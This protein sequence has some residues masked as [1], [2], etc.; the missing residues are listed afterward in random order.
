MNCRNLIF[1][2][3]CCWIVSSCS[4]T[5]ILSD[6][7][8]LLQKNSVKV[9]DPRFNSSQL[10]SYI[11]QK[12]NS[13]L[14]FGYSPAVYFYAM[15]GK[16]DTKA[17]KA[18]RQ[19]GEAPV[20]YDASLVDD[21]V[22]NLEKHL[23]Y[24]GYFGSEVEPKVSVKNKKVTVT[25]Y[26]TLGRRIP[27]SSI[28]YDLPD[29][30]FA[31]DFKKDIPNITV[32]TGDFLSEE[33][34][35]KETDRSV[36]LFHQKGYYSLS[37]GN[38]F[39]EADTLADSSKA[40]LVMSVRE[41]ARGTDSTAV[42]PLQK[43][44]FGNV[45]YS[46]PENLKFRPS[47][48]STLNLIK[49][50]ELYDSRTVDKTY[51][52]FASVGLFR[53][54]SVTTTSPENG[55]VDVNVE[56][57][58]SRIHGFKVNLEASTNSTGLVGISPQLTYTNRNIFHGGEVLNV[59]VKGNF[60]FGVKDKIFANEFSVSTSLRFPQFL[61]LPSRIFKGRSLPRTEFGASFAYQNRPEFKRTVISTNYGYNGLLF[62][63]LYYQFNP[64]QLSITR[65][66]NLSDTF[67][68][69][70]LT[71]PFVLNTYLNNFD[72]GAGLSVYYTSDTSTN[73]KGSHHFARFSMDISGNVLSLF[74]KLL[75]YD[76]LRDSHTI[77]ETPYAQYVRGE[78]QAGRTIAFGKKMN[79]AIAYR[80]LA[81]AGYAYGNSSSLPF[82]KY[83]YCGGASS[84]RGW[85]ARTVG[86]G[87]AKPYTFFV[88]PNQTGDFKLEAN[89]EYRFP[90]VRILSGAVF[91][92][93]GNVWS[94][95]QGAPDEERFTFKNLPESIAMS[96]GAGL[97]LNLN[98]ILIRL[99]MGLRLHDPA[100]DAGD[101]WVSPK[102]WF[103][104]NYALHFGVGYPF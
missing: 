16:R 87:T 52:R 43:Y 2:L 42:E 6:G 66:F 96:W 39:F 51:N 1:A 73:P 47:M 31:E 72:L 19:I 33:A 103:P 54:V 86:P 14:L 37:Q 104:K 29:G 69:K 95:Y 71:D 8:F 74:N 89:L 30:E 25:Y 83:F 56:L 20:V 35:E 53:G 57:N 64:F 93:A 58:N 62:G 94:W 40:D 12:P 50:G 15:A 84:L 101:R 80:F 32:R 10:T 36:A 18:L 26:V 7:Q 88:I 77:W 76:S 102:I 17:A 44:R 34:A 3:A 99:D 38:Y 55:I 5:R 22:E 85:Q 59:G 92:D 24:L 81:G 9:D 67:L 82:E 98:F 79:H 97:R 65:L 45:S 63:H 41:Y 49:P 46:L 75:P 78:I 23:N 4:P 48:L 28:T 60:Q 91:V 11:R 70:L 27:I 68:A 100:R 90:I 13:R 61:G 21:S